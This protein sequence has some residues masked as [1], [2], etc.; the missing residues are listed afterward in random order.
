VLKKI[1]KAVADYG[2]ANAEECV[3]LT[4]AFLRGGFHRLI[5]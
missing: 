4:L 3:T 1:A 5:D 2:A